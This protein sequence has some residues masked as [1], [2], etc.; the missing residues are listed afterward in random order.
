MAVSLMP[1]AAHLQPIT[2]WSEASSTR[3]TFA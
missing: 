2:H 1:Q 3:P